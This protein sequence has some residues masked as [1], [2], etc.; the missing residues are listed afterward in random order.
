VCA[1]G[2]SGTG[3]TVSCNTARTDPVVTS[4]CLELKCLVTSA[5]MTGLSVVSDSVTLMPDVYETSGAGG[6]GGT[7]L[8]PSG[9]N[10]AVGDNFDSCDSLAC[11]GGTEGT[12]NNQEGS[13]SGRQVTC[14]QTNPCVAD[15][16]QLPNNGY[17]F[18][19]CGPGTFGS[20]GHLTC[21]LS[22]GL[23]TLSETLDCE[24]NS[25]AA[26]N[27]PQGML[28]TECSSGVILKTRTTTSCAV[29][30][31]TGYESIGQGIVKCPE[32]ATYGQAAVSS[33]QCVPFECAPLNLPSYVQG[34]TC[35]QSQVLYANAQA[36]DTSCTVTCAAGSSGS[37]GTVQCSAVTQGQAAS[38]DSVQCTENTCIIPDLSPQNLVLSSSC[39]L[40]LKTQTNTECTIECASQYY[41]TSSSSTGTVVCGSSSADGDE[42]TFVS[43]PTCAEIACLPFSLP[44]GTF[45][46]LER[47]SARKNIALS[48]SLSISFCLS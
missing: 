33:L 44:T 48:L 3:G 4:D 2:Y 28:S 10:Y 37:G 20:G 27:F 23:Y 32:D 8:C 18:V 31:D 39:V 11:V 22:S 9:N 14:G 42:V 38:Y 30:C 21:T 19:G 15:T 29:S 25:C 36:G 6:W 41:S 34:G 17:C 47:E 26:F 40:P 46:L 13:W 24:P 5:Y 1:S 16:T 35:V 12:C 45:V 7:C 43:S